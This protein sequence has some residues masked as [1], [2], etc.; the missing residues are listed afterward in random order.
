[1]TSHTEIPSS[2]VHNVLLS[3]VSGGSLELYKEYVEHDLHK[4]DFFWI[5]LGSIGNAELCQIPSFKHKLDT[6]FI[7][8]LMGINKEIIIC[9]LPYINNICKYSK[10]IVN[11]CDIKCLKLIKILEDNGAVNVELINLLRENGKVQALEYIR[12]NLH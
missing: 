3:Y 5:T 6:V 10:Y 7:G 12:D 4:N 2:C 9:C 11:V 8:A 1:M